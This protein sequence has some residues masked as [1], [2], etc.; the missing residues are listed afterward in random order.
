MAIAQGLD[1][2]GPTGSFLLSS[3]RRA[4]PQYQDALRS[5]NSELLQSRDCPFDALTPEDQ[6][7][8]LADKN[9]DLYG[10]TFKAEGF[11][12]AAVLQAACSKV[13][14]HRK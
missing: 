13:N 7:W 2:R 10:N 4:G 6:D 3:L 5:F 9:F 11:A 8:T 14:P 12:R 1:R